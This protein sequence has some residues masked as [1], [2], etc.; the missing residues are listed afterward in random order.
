VL[1]VSLIS[2]ELDVDSSALPTAS[3]GDNVR[4]TAVRDPPKGW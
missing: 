1:A 4:Q 3:A 2:G